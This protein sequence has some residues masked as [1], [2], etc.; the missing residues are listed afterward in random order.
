[1]GSNALADCLGV[2]GGPDVPGAPCDDG[3]STT[4]GDTWDQNCNCV[5]N[6]VGNPCAITFF[7]WQ[8]WDS[9]TNQPI[10]NTLNVWVN[11]TAIGGQFQY[12]WDFGDNTT[13]NSQYPTH[14][15]AGNG[16]YLLCVT[17]SGMGCTS[18]YCDTVA[19]DTNGVIVPGQSGNAGFTINMLP[20]GSNSVVEIPAE[21]DELTIAPNPI[22]DAININ[23]SSLSN[24][25]GTVMIF[26]MSGKQ[27]LAENLTVTSGNNRARIGADGLEKGSY[28]IRI[29]ANGGVLN[30]RFVK[31]MR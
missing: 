3:D 1:M 5:G 12:F 14:T 21:L 26:D 17:V 27:V 18:T 11:T 24:G 2:I 8:P 23:F 10:L 20:N 22:S 9:L 28:L 13:S 19:I 16:P 29:E 30:K 25:N 7:V 4:V 31:V 15:Y 6:P